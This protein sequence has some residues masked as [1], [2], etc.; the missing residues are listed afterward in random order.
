MNNSLIKTVKEKSNFLYSIAEILTGDYKPHQYGDVMLPMVVLK[1][2]DD[3]LSDTKDAVI[4]AAK[5]YPE[6][7][8]KRDFILKEIS[9]NNFYNTSNFDFKK[10]LNEPND[11]EAN[12]YN[13]LDGFSDE[14]K[15]IMEK[16]KIKDQI[17]K[18]S[19]HNIL[20]LIIDKFNEPQANM[21]PSKVT[22]I[23]M[24]YIFEEIIRRYNEL[25]NEDA[26]QHYTPREVIELMVNLVFEDQ[27]DL[28]DA[29]KIKTVYDGACGTGGMLTGS[30]EYVKKLNSSSKLLCYGQEIEDATYAVCK[31]DMLIKGE[32]PNNIRFGST[33]SNDQF[34]GEKFDYI[35]M[36]PPFGRDWKKDK[37]KVEKEAEK[38]ADGRFFAGTPPI[39]DSQL[40]FLQNAVSKMKS[41]GSKVAII[42]NGSALWNGEAGKSESEI[43]RYIIEN[44]LLDCIV[45][46]PTNLFYNTPITTYIWILSNNKPVHRKNKIQLINAES[47]YKKM[48]KSLGEKKNEILP[49]QIKEI[50]K[51]YGEF[52]QN[53]YS[54]IFEK[55]F[56]G[57][58]LI[59]VLLPKY[60]D[61]K[62]V[63]MKNN[64]V[65]FDKKNKN[66]EFIPLSTNPIEYFEK[67]V[68]PYY[69]DANF[70]KDEIK[71]GYSID[72]VKYFHEP[73]KFEKTT[74]IMKKINQN[75]N[76]IENA[77][78]DL[79]DDVEDDNISFKIEKYLKVKNCFVVAKDKAHLDDP[80]ILSL[81]RDGVRIR[82]IS[83]NE[84]QLADSYYDYNPV[85]KNDLLLNPMDLVSGANCTLSDKE[86]VISPAYVN[87]RNKKGYYSKYYDYFFKTQ[88]WTRN[89][90]ACGKGVSFDNRWTLNNDAL[91]N[92]KIPVIPYDTQK[93]IADDLDVKINKINKAKK[94]LEDQIQL[95]E[96]YKR[97]LIN[98]RVLGEEKYE[99]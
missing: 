38:G 68:K 78:K 17:Q 57:Y 21:H 70:E 40:L 92:Y 20:Y 55:S 84:G 1:R 62:N 93:K 80:V 52:V 49:N 56:F 43:R 29:S 59:N 65:V 28:A 64:K 60:D 96:R 58:Q 18:L 76:L 41:E 98:E 88:Y 61:N 51:I 47:F 87:L 10:L 77:V 99:L 89:F 24:G 44:D 31:A 3:V 34:T 63:V 4:E 23:E 32:N 5:K 7:F 95:L 39:S 22:N 75:T 13:Y 37:E 9:K 67:E 25:S 27:S 81:A 50:T 14:V 74:E 42:H 54:K 26:G 85:K 48:R 97:S 30:M 16:F 6:T 69:E 19:E 94:E 15:D 35:I 46:L 36:N 82:D 90:F 33:L 53:K 72:F 11:I 66:K 12:F 71:I 79:F 83:T 91:M 2:F 86:G 8:A 45:Q 73:I